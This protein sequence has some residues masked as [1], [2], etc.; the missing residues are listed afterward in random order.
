MATNFGS[1]NGNAFGV[2]TPGKTKKQ[3]E[4]ERSRSPLANNALN[5]ADENSP[6]FAKQATENRQTSKE[7]AAKTGGTDKQY[8]QAASVNTIDPATRDLNAKLGQGSLSVSAAVNK[9]LSS[10]TQAG[11]N[12][13]LGVK[14][15]GGKDVTTT[16]PTIDASGNL[17]DTTATT[18]TPGSFNITGKASFDQTVSEEEKQ[19]Q[20]NALRDTEGFKASFKQGPDGRWI[21]KTFAEIAQDGINNGEIGSYTA[22]D[23]AKKTDHLMLLLKQL[24][25]LEDAG[26][27][28][29]S[30]AQAIQSTIMNEDEDGVVA[31]LIMAKDKYKRLTGVADAGKNLSWSGDKGSKTFNV[32]DIANLTSADISKEMSSALKDPAGGGLFGG[33]W[34]ETMLKD[35]DTESSEYKLS[36]DREKKL[37]ED[38]FK[39]ATGFLDKWGKQFTEQDVIVNKTLG[40]L[41]PKIIEELRKSGAGEE[42]IAWFQTASKGDLAKALREAIYDKNSG[43]GADQRAQLEK[44]LGEL[45]GQ[46]TDATRKGGMIASWM[47]QLQKTGA[48]T[49]EDG[50]EVKPN[51]DQ[52]MD[53][54]NILNNSTLTDEQKAAALE[55]KFTDIAINQNAKLTTAMGEV[56]KGNAT[57]KQASEQMLAGMV[58]SMASIAGSKLEEIIQK[59]LGVGKEVTGKD[60]ATLITANPQ[61]VDEVLQDS[62]GQQSE[63]F[64]TQ[65]NTANEKAVALVGKAQ[66]T[67]KEYRTKAEAQIAG[68]KEKLKARILETS[69][70]P[71]KIQAQL[72]ELDKQRDE[73]IA[74]VSND[75]NKA[76]AVARGAGNTY[77]MSAANRSIMDAAIAKIETEYDQQHDKL[78]RAYNDAT[79]QTKAYLACGNPDDPEFA[80]RLAASDNPSLSAIGKIMLNN[81]K[82]VNDVIASNDAVA[83]RATDAV[84]LL[85]RFK[86]YYALKIASPSTIIGMNIAL[87]KLVGSGDTGGIP[88]DVLANVGQPKPTGGYY[89]LSDVISSYLASVGLSY[90][91]ATQ[92]QPVMFKGG[93]GAT[94]TDIATAASAGDQ[95][96][97]DYSGPEGATLSAV[98]YMPAQLAATKWEGSEDPYI[99]DPSAYYEEPATEVEDPKVTRDRDPKTPIGKGSI[100]V[101]NWGGNPKAGPSKV[102]I[103]NADGTKTIVTDISEDEIR[104]MVSDSNTKSLTWGDVIDKV[105]ANAGTILKVIGGMVAGPIGAMVGK[106]AGTTITKVAGT[107]TTT[108]PVAATEEPDTAAEDPVIEYPAG[109]DA[110]EDPRGKEPKEK[111]SKD[112]DN[113]NDGGSSRGSLRGGYAS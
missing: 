44:Y 37:N 68:D 98:D 50:K 61:L 32:A 41:A 49:D 53:I 6:D 94:A 77:T 39:A 40:D 20:L 101:I 67:A 75:P 97:N 112:N 22:L 31:G 55:K 5:S 95:V 70:L 15:S 102:E 11:F 10:P 85:G 100:K 19:K 58:A 80:A 83:K 82:T 103:T 24:Q 51:A 59:K 43:L 107:P 73:R 30:E 63:E 56:L 86:S 18:T 14:Y 90:D 62:V 106:S 96:I 111:P 13:D 87:A 33:D 48:F 93:G 91:G 36:S 34:A 42:A 29:S 71:A 46:T 4:M 113:D 69:Q 99:G 16:V 57:I 78:L 12:S 84:A 104:D 92:K 25:G 109:T 9:F 21:P 65:W 35:I 8:N 88:P 60:M 64:N 1:G 76:A 3:S 79:D 105:T 28:N 47:T 81:V 108:P 38:V 7:A 66:T 110:E 26:M 27:G 52:K 72:V 2:G 17:V 89:S 23:K 74:A 54:L 45:T